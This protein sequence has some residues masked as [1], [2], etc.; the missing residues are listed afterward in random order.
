M[1]N[2]WTVDKL[3]EDIKSKVIDEL[4]RGVPPNQIATKYD[5][6]EKCLREYNKK[7]ILPN[8]AEEIA[9]NRQEDVAVFIDEINQHKA[10]MVDVLNALKKA[11]LNKKTGEY[12]FSDPRRAKTYVELLNKT[13][14]TVLAYLTMLAKITGD[15]KDVVEITYRPTI[16][17]E[18]IAQLIET[19]ESKEDMIARLRLISIS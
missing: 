13:A 5:V 4:R 12:D 17:L 8:M 19:S 14:Q 15:M 18:Q 9:K 2:A 3:P 6:P 1:A 16:I 7:R 11:V 10:E